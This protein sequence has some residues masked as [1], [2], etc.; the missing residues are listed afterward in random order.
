M[1]T[2]PD[3]DKQWEFENNFYLTCDVSRIGKFLVHY[4]LFKM[5]KDIPGDIVECGVFKGLSLIRFVTFINLLVKPPTTKRLIA[6]DTFDEFPNTE[7]VKDRQKHDEFVGSAGGHSIGKEQLQ[8]V[9]TR[10]GT[11]QGD[12]CET[13]PNYVHE[14][15]ISKSHSSTWIP[16]STNR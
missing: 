5:T 7:F 15:P 8:K 10:K 12:I 9:L 13:V 1:I 6:F 3:F 11:V 16:T 14:H 4:E 2:L